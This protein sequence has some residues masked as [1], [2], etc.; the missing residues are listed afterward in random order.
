M[1]KLEYM[2]LES[3]G[4]KAR[5]E[6]EILVNR[7]ISE[8]WVPQGGVMISETNISDYPYTSYLQAMIRRLP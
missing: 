7:A 2:I 4:N 1:P 5:S 3:E 6:L 8:D